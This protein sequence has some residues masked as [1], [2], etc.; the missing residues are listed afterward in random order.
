MILA[1]TTCLGATVVVHSGSTSS[2]ANGSDFVKACIYR[3]AS[4][5]GRSG[6]YKSLLNIGRILVCGPEPRYGSKRYSPTGFKIRFIKSS[7][8]IVWLI[9]LHFPCFKHL[10]SIQEIKWNMLRP[11]SISDNHQVTEYTKISLHRYPLN[12]GRC[13][14]TTTLFQLVGVSKLSLGD[15]MCKSQALSRI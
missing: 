1:V 9:Q 7:R 14:L 10:A 6:R 3:V 13:F 4:S 8:K 11:S 2:I 12:T 15:A 5:H